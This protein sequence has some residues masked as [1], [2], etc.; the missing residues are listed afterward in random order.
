MQQCETCV[1]KGRRDDHVEDFQGFYDFEFSLV[2]L[3]VDA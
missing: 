3:L 2:Q 1:S